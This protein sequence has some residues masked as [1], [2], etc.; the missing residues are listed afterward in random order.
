MLRLALVATFAP[1]AARAATESPVRK[2]LQLLGDL[3]AKIIREG[4][5][6]QKT[7]HEFSEWC[8]ER[9][10]NL[11]FEIKTAKSKIGDLQASIDRATSEMSAMQTKIEDTA[12]V[13][14]T[15]E[16]D[17][18]AATSIRAQEEADFAA[19][20]KELTEIVD[21]LTRAIGLLE[22][23]ARKHGAAMVQSTANGGVVKALRALVDASELGAQDADKL[24]ALV[25]QSQQQSD[26]SDEEQAPQA[27]VYESHSGSIIETLEGLLD[28]AE[29]ELDQARKK[30][31]SAKHNFEMLKQSLEDEM[32]FGNQDITE[33]K[34]RLASQTEIKAAAEGDLEM[35]SKDLATDEKTQSTL[36]QDCQERAQDFE[37]E[38]KSRGEELKAIVEAKKVLSEMTGGADS[39]AYGLSQASFLQLVTISGTSSLR[40]GADLA[41]FEA[42]RFV[43]NLA[44]RENSEALAQ[45]ARRMASAMRLGG[46]SSNDPF[47]KVKQLI[48]DMIVSLERDA[49]TDAT[50]K[51]YCDKEMQ[52][53]A[54]K[55][56]EKSHDVDKLTTQLDSMSSKSVQLKQDIAATQ[57][58][59]SELTR[60]QAE[61]TKIRSEEKAEYEQNKPEMQAGLQ[62]VR[63]ALKILREYYAKDGAAHAT[64]SGSGKSIIGLLE[65][66]ES[67]FTKSLAEMN[68]AEN[69]AQ[70]EYDKD[71]YANQIEKASKETS[72][73]HMT[74]QAAN[75][76]KSIS[77]A[78]SDLEGLQTELSAVLEYKMK[79]DDICVAKPETYGERAA[80]REAEI[81][82]LKEALQILEGEAVLLQ[83]QG[84]AHLRGGRKALKQHAPVLKASG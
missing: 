78:K 36:K 27:A 38:V 33:A 34:K 83:R 20:E 29:E 12:G 84:V 2:V 1:L 42:V 5:A 61:A 16:A 82:G 51:A 31:V 11:G 75:L 40:T 41:N 53:T 56:L 6:S 71:S 58:A 35:T 19:E 54:Q 9:N 63:M 59:I 50:H 49:K 25:Q 62:G 52:E 26:D 37:S 18:K 15:N 80:R 13:L 44:R 66:V 7:F 22:R 74:R 73:K 23:E 64:S 76:E 81:A 30:E 24:A 32:K 45:L 70:S 68:V 4:E 39:I 43:R 48:T 79:L 55:K 47:A 69:T 8:E 3:E 77:E 67:D 60:A 14:S 65:V 72:I 17:L 57:N 21:L 28:K 10:V 46:G